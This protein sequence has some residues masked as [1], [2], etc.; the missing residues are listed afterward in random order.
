MAGGQR[1]YLPSSLCRSGFT[2]DRSWHG[3]PPISKSTGGR[4][5]KTDSSMSHTSPSWMTLP[6]KLK[7]WILRQ[8]F[9]ISLEKYEDGLIPN[10]CN[11]IKPLE[12]PS[13][14]LRTTGFLMMVLFPR[15][16]ISWYCLPIVRFKRG[17]TTR[18]FCNED[19]NT[20]INGQERITLIKGKPQSK[21]MIV[22]Y[23]KISR[24][25]VVLQS[26]IIILTIQPSLVYSF[27]ICRATGVFLL[28]EKKFRLAHVLE[29]IEATA[30]REKQCIATT[31]A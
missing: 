12:I 10:L 31:M 29:I 14:R 24:I 9:S 23:L 21:F 16:D 22:K 19:V 15:R 4:P 26:R 17:R 7:R 6:P 2:R 1:T 13:K 11:A 27:A 28:F 25:A 8:Y 5:F 18:Q 3:L 20:S 30:Q